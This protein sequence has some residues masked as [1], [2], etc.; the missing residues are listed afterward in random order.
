M[1]FSSAPDGRN[2][3]EFLESL[4]NAMSNSSV[5]D[6]HCLNADPNPDHEPKPPC[7]SGSWLDFKS[8]SLILT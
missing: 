4:T 7:G 5:V 3:A 1:L 6:P 2:V 8:Q